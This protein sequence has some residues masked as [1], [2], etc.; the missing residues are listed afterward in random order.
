MKNMI[1]KNE[2]KNFNEGVWN[3]H[4]YKIMYSGVYAKFTQNPELKIRLLATGEK[5]LVEAS[6]YDKIWG[7]GYNKS[8]ALPNINNWG[9]NLLGQILMEVRTNIKLIQK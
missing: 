7:I 6:P 4:K 1:Q 9:Q 2:V 3:T 5:F 8:D